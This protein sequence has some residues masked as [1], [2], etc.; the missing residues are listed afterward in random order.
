MPEYSTVYLKL[1]VNCAHN[2]YVGIRGKYEV[3][4]S[5]LFVCECWLCPRVELG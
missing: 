4:F 2:L 1:K 3:R 5:Y